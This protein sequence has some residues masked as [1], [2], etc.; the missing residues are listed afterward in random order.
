MELAAQFYQTMEMAEESANYCLK[1]L[2]YQYPLLNTKWTKVDH[3]DWALNMA[4]LSQYFVGKNHF[5]SACHM[6][7]SARKVLNETD[8][9]IKQKE[10]DSFNKAHA[11]LDIIEVKYCLSIFDESR[12]SMDK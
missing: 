3:I 1:S 2:R 10:T 8:E 5:E 11:D 9:Q 7:A 12:E 6:M 4:T